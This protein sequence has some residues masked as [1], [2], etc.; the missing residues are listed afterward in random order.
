MQKM[1]AIFLQKKSANLHTQ[2]YVLKVI[3]SIKCFLQILMKFRQKSMDI[4]HTNG[5]PRYKQ[6][7]LEKTI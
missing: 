5:K 7:N 2:V 1:C 4:E 6:M 3:V